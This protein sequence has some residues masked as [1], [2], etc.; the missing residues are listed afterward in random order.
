[1]IFLLMALDYIQLGAG[2]S[3]SRWLAQP[4]GGCKTSGIIIFLSPA[5]AR[6]LAHG[7]V[8]FGQRVAH[9]TASQPSEM[10]T[11][12]ERAKHLNGFS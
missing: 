8:A 9:Q 5:F 6:R 10:A 1:M 12:R 4:A 11:D 3:C 2:Q 7:N